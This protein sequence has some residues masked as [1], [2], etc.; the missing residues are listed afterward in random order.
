MKKLVLSISL[1]L[2]ALSVASPVLAQSNVGGGSY[3]VNKNQLDKVKPYN[4]PRQIDI[5]DERPIIHNH[6]TPE[7]LPDTMEIN[8]TI[9]AP[10]PGK[11]VVVGGP[12]GGPSAAPYRTGNPNLNS[13]NG[14]APAND[15]YKSNI[16]ARGPA[17]ASNLPDAK[18]TG[19]HGPT[20][21]AAM[22]KKVNAR[23][24]TP[25]NSGAGA[26]P[27]STVAKG[28]KDYKQGGGSSAPIQG[29]GTVTG[30]RLP[31]GALTKRLLTK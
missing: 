5:I 22:G 25:I 19:V 28:Y 10:I 4:A 24:N 9:P 1:G 12:S 30:K 23:L 27:Q 6:L 15:M 13:T 21:E 29:T 17:S 31:P 18:S 7:Q 11:H 16:P 3:K 2:I 8:A 26:I 14:L 20:G